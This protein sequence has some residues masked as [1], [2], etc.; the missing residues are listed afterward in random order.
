M[1]TN[2]ILRC[3]RWLS[4]THEK[5]KKVSTWVSDGSE[6]ESSEIGSAIGSRSQCDKMVATASKSCTIN[7]QEQTTEYCLLPE[8]CE[9]TSSVVIVE[10]KSRKF[11]SGVF[12][13]VASSLPT[14]DAT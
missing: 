10:R 8:K 14:N 2:R 5:D 6:S 13:P 9:T 12:Q 11:A 7:S 4:K 1:S 3:L